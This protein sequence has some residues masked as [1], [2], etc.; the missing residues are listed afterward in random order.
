[1]PGYAITNTIGNVPIN[2]GTLTTATAEAGTTGRIVNAVDPWWGGGEFIYG[3]AGGA[4]RQFGLCVINPAYASGEW[5]FTMTEAP[6]TAILGRPV[7]VAPVA[8]D[9]GEFGWFQIGGVT[10]V[11]CNASVAADTTFSIAATG[12]GG[13]AAA[14]KQVVNA[15]IIAAGSTTVAKTNCSSISGSYTLKVT[16]ASGWFCGAY[17]SGTGVGTGAVVTD[18]SPDGLTVTMSVVTTAA[19]TGTVTATYNNSTVYYNVAH[20]NRPF[21]QGAIT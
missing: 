14:G 7:C 10:P 3:K 1:M 8:M 13:A 19:I 12:Q 4:I 9:S 15:R 11:N 18:I 16:N 6:S 21:A 17:L 5:V 20:I 2:F